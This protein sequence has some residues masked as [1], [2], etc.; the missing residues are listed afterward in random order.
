MSKFLFITK[1]FVVEPLGIMY[2]SGSLRRAGHDTY[3]LTT[4]DNLEKEV[5]KLS[6]DFVGYSV[7]TGDHKFFDEVNKNLRSKFDF[8]SVAGG[9]HPTFFPNYIYGSSFDAVCVGEGDS[10]LV[11]LVN[12][13][14]NNVVDNFSKKLYQEFDTVVF[15]NPLRHLVGNLDELPFPDRELIYSRDES[16]RN[17]PIKHFIAGR[18]CPYKCTYC[19]NHCYNDLYKG[20][21]KMVRFRSVDNLL[22]EVEDVVAKYPTKFVYF[23]D[24]TFILN[25]GWLEEFSRKYSG[26]INIPFHAHVR[27]NLVSEDKIKLLKNAN[28]FSVHIAVESGNDRL[29]N[30]VL[31]R[32]MSEK[33]IYDACSLLHKYGIKFMLQNIL[34]L[35]TGSLKNDFETLEMNIK[36]KPTYAWAS[37]FQ[38]YPGTDLAKL[39]LEKGLIEE[40]NLDDIQSSFFDRSLL[41]IC[42]RK[43]TEYL[44]KLF[45]VATDYPII[46]YSGLLK[47]L[48][49]LPDDS[50]VR[51]LL[52]KLYKAYRKT[53]DEKLYGMK[54]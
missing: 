37:I 42:N 49:K 39:C 29:R 23:Q 28:C 35:P 20:K 6:P 26:R 53:S 4:G 40:S 45:A 9:P 36:C 10:A 31:K 43:E 46:Y 34:G 2:L 52:N 41:N 15:K 25:K 54:L 21:G 12:N 3:W 8:F 7:M 17:N 47:T 33:Q 44:Q 22:D 14:E 1:P 19:F 50:K 11:D 32:N 51:G 30:D 38:P 27:A 13:P 18:G 24:D 16:Q 5:G 48:L